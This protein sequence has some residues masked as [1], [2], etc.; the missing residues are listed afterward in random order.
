MQLSQIHHSQNKKICIY[1]R[2]RGRWE[3]IK[4]TIS[5]DNQVMTSM[6]DR[7]DEIF[8]DDHKKMPLAIS[9]GEI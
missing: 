6:I 7:T 9:K 4:N 1:K 2:N 5:R 8:E 3:N